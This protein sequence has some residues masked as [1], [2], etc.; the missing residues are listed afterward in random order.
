MLFYPNFIPSKT[1]RSSRNKQ[2]LFSIEKSNKPRSVLKSQRDSKQKMKNIK[3]DKS[4]AAF[5]FSSIFCQIVAL[6]LFCL[7]VH[8]GF[9]LSFSPKARRITNL[10]K[11]FILSVESW[12]AYYTL[13]A[14]MLETLFYNNTF[15]MWD[16]KLTTYDFYYEHREKTKEYILENI[17]RS[18]DY[19]LGNFTDKYRSDM[20]KVM[21]ML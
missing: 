2:S 6:L 18:L 8:G 16:G 12:N 20:T 9:Y 10:S 13:H 14:A 15:R 5:G 1:K 4:T 7:S 21:H 17:T 11:V 3:L 19:D